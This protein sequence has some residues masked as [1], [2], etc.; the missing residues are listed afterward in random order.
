[1]TRISTLWSCLALLNTFDNTAY[2]ELASTI[3]RII[4]TLGKENRPLLS[5]LSRL[6]V[7]SKYKADGHDAW[8]AGWAIAHCYSGNWRKGVLYT[9]ERKI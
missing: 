8:I 2:H 6:A 7:D 5:E 9:L 3:K 1:M 4:L